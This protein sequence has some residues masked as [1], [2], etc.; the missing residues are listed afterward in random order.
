MSP[1]PLHYY[2]C[3]K[4]P[5]RL[6]CVQSFAYPP[7]AHPVQ[8]PAPPGAMASFEDDQAP[9]FV[10]AL[11]PDAPYADN[12]G[13][14]QAEAAPEVQEPPAYAAAPD[15]GVLD[16]GAPG[17]LA[18]TEAV[19][20]AQ[21]RALEL[22]AQFAV[23]AQ[24]DGTDTLNGDAGGSMKRKFDGEDDDAPDAKRGGSLLEVGWVADR[25]LVCYSTPSSRC[26][27]RQVMGCTCYRGPI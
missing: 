1:W 2:A 18:S 14:E 17:G 26:A 7:P 19:L 23:Q 8:L 11:P 27:R 3:D 15:V 9:P 16:A 22:A 10:E 12:N 13:A 6:I 25:L 24:N 4:E 21:R 20:A 5:G